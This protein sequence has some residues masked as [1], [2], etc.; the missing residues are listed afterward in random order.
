MNISR[1]GPA[2]QGRV[3]AAQEWRD[4]TFLHWR[5]SPDEVA[6]LL[7]SGVVPDVLGGST[8]V[9]LIAFRLGNARVGFL[10]TPSVWGSFTEVNVRLYA[11]DGR[12]RRG[13]VFL[14]LEASS[15]PAV[16]A[17]RALFSIPYF[18]AR[19]A[20]RS[21]PGGW[22]YAAKRIS[23]QVPANSRAPRFQLAA[24]VDTTSTVDDELSRFLTARWGLFQRRRGRTQWLP[25]T[26]EPWELHPAEVV[27][28][29]DELCEAAG[30]P[31]L[32]Q[33][34][35]DSVLFSPGVNAKFGRGEFL[36]SE[37]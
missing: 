31:G 2:L 15:L 10:P 17:A 36:A 6:H 13:V 29:R 3:V 28:L 8:W 19:T 32:S 27:T 7:P 11:V 4:V 35:P 18:W 16:I 30:I 34:P 14:S 26:H 5:V 25:N 33:R 12:G 23:P 37:Q 1:S 24:S 22:E 9:G 21:R 20:Q